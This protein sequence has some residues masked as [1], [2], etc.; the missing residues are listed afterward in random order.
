MA[1]PPLVPTAPAP[2]AAEAVE[3]NCAAAAAAT[4]TTARQ[5]TTTTTTTEAATIASRRV[6]GCAHTKIL[7]AC[8]LTSTHTCTHTQWEWVAGGWQ[9]EAKEM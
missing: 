6:V 4:T 1:A 2:A 7:R 9:S 3:E 5:C 8:E